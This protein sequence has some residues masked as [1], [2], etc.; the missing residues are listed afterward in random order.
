MGATWN[1]QDSIHRPFEK[2]GEAL[3]TPTV[4]PQSNLTFVKLKSR[5]WAYISFIFAELF[6]PRNFSSQKYP[7]ML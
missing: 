3:E 6:F 4:A 1:T 7:M 2:I 5:I